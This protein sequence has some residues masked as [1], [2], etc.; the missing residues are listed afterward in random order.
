MSVRVTIRDPAGTARRIL[1]KQARIY[2]NTRLHAYCSPYVPM[3]SGNLDQTVEINEEC[4]HYKSPYAH[5]QWE[6]K[7][8]GPNYPITEN[9][10]VV[11]FVSPSEKYPTNRNLEYS[12]DKHPLATSHWER[13]M[14]VAK[15]QQLADDIS[16]YL[17]RR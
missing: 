9:G 3:D 6:G 10:Q 8:Y 15:G 17:S 1:D 11:G 14:A 4:V 5:Y 16:E 7:V 2:A 13:A 12:K